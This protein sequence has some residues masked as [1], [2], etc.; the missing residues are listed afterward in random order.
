V[1]QFQGRI[2]FLLKL[3]SIHNGKKPKWYLCD[4]PFWSILQRVQD[5]K[6]SLSWSKKVKSVSREP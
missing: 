3:L 6:K 4:Q 1:V 2:L 5:R